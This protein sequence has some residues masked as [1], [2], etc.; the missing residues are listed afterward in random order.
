M[1]GEIVDLVTI[2]C[3]LGGWMWTGDTVDLTRLVGDRRLYRCCTCASL[4]SLWDMT[5]DAWAFPLTCVGCRTKA[6]GSKSLIGAVSSSIWSGSKCRCA[7]VSTCCYVAWQL[8]GALLPV[9]S[10]H[11]CSIAYSSSWGALLWH[12]IAVANFLVALMILLTGVIRMVLVLPCVSCTHRSC[13][14]GGIDDTIVFQLR[15]K[16]PGLDCMVAPHV[17]MHG[18]EVDHHLSSNWGHGCGIKI[19]HSLHCFECW[20]TRVESTRSHQD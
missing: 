1:L 20:Q 19:I 18:L 12:L 6:G 5:Y 16:V 3:T 11:K 2:G 8:V 17:P 9:M 10:A 4:L 15:C 7:R 14:V 13:L